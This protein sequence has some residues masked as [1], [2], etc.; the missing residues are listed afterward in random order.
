MIRD[1]LP[2]RLIAVHTECLLYVLAIRLDPDTRTCNSKDYRNII[3]ACFIF[4]M[5]VVEKHQALLMI[6]KL[7]LKN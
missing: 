7:W 3:L 4:D 2:P 1:F 5:S 6:I